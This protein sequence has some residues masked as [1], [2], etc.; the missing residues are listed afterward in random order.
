MKDQVITVNGVIITPKIAGALQE[1]KQ[2]E[3]PTQLK[4]N[5]TEILFMLAMNEAA[6]DRG[7]KFEDALL[8]LRCFYR[9]A[10]SFSEEGGKDGD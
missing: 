7:E 9:I 2:F 3:D 5:I 10:E 8:M 4:D 1:L 6:R